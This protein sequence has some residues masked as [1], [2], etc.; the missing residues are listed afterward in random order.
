[1]FQNDP[2]L[3]DAQAVKLD[4]AGGTGAGTK[5]P[6]TPTQPSTVMLT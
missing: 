3:S 4:E 6:L 5:H 2:P 1:M